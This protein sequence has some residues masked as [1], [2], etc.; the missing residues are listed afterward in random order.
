MDIVIIKNNFQNLLDVAIANPTHT[1][2]VQRVSMMIAHVTI[3]AT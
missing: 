2:L 1:N 3:V